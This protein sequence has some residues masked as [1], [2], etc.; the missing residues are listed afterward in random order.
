M[1][2]MTRFAVLLC[3]ASLLAACGGT[4]APQSTAVPLA[5]DVPPTAIP[6]P[7]ATTTAAVDLVARAKSFVDKF[8]QGDDAA[9]VAML[10]ATMKSAL[11]IE[12]VGE[13]RDTLKLQA[14]AFK[15]QTGTRTERADPYDVVYVTCEFEAMTLDVKVVFD[16]AGL[17]A[18][19]FF[20]PAEYVPPAYVQPDSFTEQE[21]TVGSG[22]WA[23]PGTLA[24]PKGDGPFPVVVLVHGSGPQDRDETIA[25]NKPFRDLAWGLASRG[26]AVLRYEKRT[27]QYAS[28]FTGEMLANLTLQTETIDDALAAV[29]LLRQTP[30]IDPN[31]IYVLGHSQGGTALPRIGAADPQIAGLIS[32]AGVTRPLEDLIVEQITYI[33]GLDGSISAE[34]QADLDT[35]AAQVARVKD[36]NLS[37]ATPSYELPLS[38]PAAFW[39]DMRGYSPAEMAAGLKIPMLILQ[40]ERDY[41]V[42]TADFDGW[43]AALSSRADVQFKL[44][45]DLNHLFMTGEGKSVPS[46]YDVAGHVAEPV[47][48]DIANWI[49]A[50]PG[51]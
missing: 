17:V 11:P 8:L 4:P 10:D 42:T 9:V 28:K 51:Q 34:E 26:I 21:V 49:S 15:Q 27:R 38:I 19:L 29:A 5:T 2:T 24:M 25:P 23:L 6:V 12:K 43:K 32:L 14:G 20:L 45:P 18:G 7:T 46:E 36:P 40:G 1:K 44:Y 16:S 33:D 37:P 35:L 48:V 50:L 3:V 22:E 13:L 41:Q 31:R 30:G 47:I 39:L